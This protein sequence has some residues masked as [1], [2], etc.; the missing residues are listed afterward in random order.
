[1]KVVH[2]DNGSANGRFV[3]E[4]QAEMQ[5]WHKSGHAVAP[6]PEDGREHRFGVCPTCGDTDHLPNGY[7]YWPPPVILRIREGEG[8]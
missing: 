3:E 4:A 5:L 6:V 7:L 1:V 2:V 8:S